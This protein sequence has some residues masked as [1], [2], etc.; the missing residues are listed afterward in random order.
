MSNDSVLSRDRERGVVAL[1]V[2]LQ[3]LYQTIAS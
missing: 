1:R 3:Y 2:L